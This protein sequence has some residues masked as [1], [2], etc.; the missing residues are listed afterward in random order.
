MGASKMNHGLL[1]KSPDNLQK[2]DYYMV[3]HFDVARTG[4]KQQFYTLYREFTACLVGYW[5][6]HIYQYKKN[7]RT[8]KG[9][10]K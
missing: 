7:L 10:T 4:E 6:H 2:G 3:E 5:H 1:T 9:R 8:N